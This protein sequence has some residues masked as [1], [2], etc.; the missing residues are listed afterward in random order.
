[1]INKENPV[2]DNTIIVVPH[3]LN[4]DSYLDIIEPLKGKARRD[5]FDEAFYY[6]LPLTVGNQYGFAIKSTRDFIVEWSGNK[7]P[8]V[9]TITDGSSDKYQSIE[10][11]F[12]NGIVTVQ[13]RFTLRT[14]PGINLITIQP[15][16]IFI[17][18][19]VAMTGV[20]E[21]DNLGRDFTF[22][23]KMTVPGKVEIKSGD[24]VAAFM[25]IPRYFVEKF[26][27]KHVLD[28]FD[29]NTMSKEME[30]FNR[31]VNLRRTEDVNKKH[32]AGRLYFNGLDSKGN[33]FDDHQ[34]GKLV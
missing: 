21:S 11:V 3:F 4:D 9:I 2:P 32:N 27:V 1:M 33:K 16:N 12:G 25:P 19:M 5:W 14:P 28:V 8:A 20:I 13:N 30:E 10:N 23:M 26:D 17:P 31:L 24:V 29:E 7:E 34:G 15:P 6:C 18:S 22:N